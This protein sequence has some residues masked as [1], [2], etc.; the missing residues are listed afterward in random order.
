MPPTQPVTPPP[1]YPTSAVPAQPVSA[2]PA[3]PTSGYP[4]AGAPYSAVP[5]GPAAPKKGPAVLVLSILVGVLVLALGTVTTLYL[6]KA[7]DASKQEK[8]AAAQAATDAKNLEDVK[9]QLTTTKAEAEK[10]KQDLEGAKNANAEKLKLLSAC[11]DAVDKMMSSTTQ[12]AFN[13]AF[14]AMRAACEAAQI[15]TS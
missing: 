13:K 2:G 14:P 10:L 15:A 4:A 12:A 11:V 6:V 3:Y 1:G 9:A 5:A 8:A 7:S